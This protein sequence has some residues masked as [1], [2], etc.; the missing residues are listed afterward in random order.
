MKQG[1]EKYQLQGGCFATSGISSTKPILIH[2]DNGR[3]DRESDEGGAGLNGV[4]R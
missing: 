1:L 3:T 4:C 2:N